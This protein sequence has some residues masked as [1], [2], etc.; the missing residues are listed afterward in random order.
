MENKRKVRCRWG[1]KL[2]SLLPRS[3]RNLE[4]FLCYCNYLLFQSYL[5]FHWKTLFSQ[6]F[7]ILPSHHLLAQ[8]QQWMCE[9]CSKETIK[10]SEKSQWRR[11]GV[12]I[13]NFEQISHNVLAF[14][15]LILNKCR[16]GSFQSHIWE[17]CHSHFILNHSRLTL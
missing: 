3:L 10:M 9:I 17:R 1:G 12:F 8:I 4:T 14:P 11:S 15:Y 16:L 13:V 2:T 5:Y 6:S 7:V